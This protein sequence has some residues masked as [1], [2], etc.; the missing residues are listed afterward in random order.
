MDFKQINI[1]AAI[2][3]V[4]LL[5]LAFLTFYF[6]FVSDYWLMSIWTGALVLA[7]L[8][9]ILRLI[10]KPESALK[11]FLMEIKHGEFKNTYI[12][13][14]HKDDLSFAF[15]Q[16]MDVYRNLRIQ[17]ETN[18]LYLQTVVEHVDTALLCMDEHE[19]IVLSNR[20]AHDLFNRS[21]LN[22]LSV[23]EKNDSDLAG[24]CRSLKQQ[25][26][27][28][29][30]YTSGGVQ[31]NLS[32]RMVEFKLGELPYKLIS[33]QDIK[34]ELEE[35]ELDSWKK[36]VKVLTHEIMNTAIPISTLAS[37]INQ[38]FLDDGGKAKSLKD[39]D[40]DD[41]KDILHS[42]QTIEKRSKGIV[43]FVKATKSYTSI[44][45][46]QMETVSL[47]TLVENV[48]SLFMPGIE[49][50]NIVLK[51]DFTKQQTHIHADPKLIEQVLI[52][53]FKNAIE[54]LLG[55]N[56]PAISIAIKKS[57]DGRAQLT[58]SDNGCGMS[59]ETLE[60]IFVPFF[61]TKKEGSGIGL[62]LSKQVM[63]MM[64]GSIY[65]SSEM[66]F[67]TTIKLVF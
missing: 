33:F 18:Y 30:K 6:V 39:F 61:T 45:E 67:G 55:V 58:I 59:P 54:A 16:I 25:N 15:G 1:K 64:G 46:P 3:M 63:H 8:V 34:T 26:K 41:H 40:D 2:Y 37:V 35:Q 5:V 49:G 21:K 4:C 10:Q 65:V 32:I 62:S 24:L 66:G 42:L 31:H 17:K 20:A 36:L 9:L 52:N 38:M 29:Y 51:P 11:N 14:P 28:L 27:A 22:D 7:F 47:N 19:N 48:I 60:N 50:N 12:S 53:L 43:D 23:I 56:T 44:P 57:P 13:K